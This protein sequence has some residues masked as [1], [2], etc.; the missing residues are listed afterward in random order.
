MNTNGAVTDPTGASLQ[1]ALAPTGVPLGV[2]A[3]SQKTFGAGVNY[4]FGPAVAGFVYSHTKLTQFF[5]TELSGTFRDE[6]LVAGAGATHA[7]LHVFLPGAGW[8]PYD[9]TNSPVG[10][11]DLIRVAFT[12]KPE[13]AAPV[14][15][16]WLGD[17]QDFMSMDV[18]ASVWRIEQQA[19]RG[20]CR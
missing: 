3:N 19:E 2:L 6:P 18:R 14:C 13:Q 9:P 15:G 7:W 20:M 17:A 11:T 8:V 16:S 4:T 5:Q 1:G 12:R 10:G